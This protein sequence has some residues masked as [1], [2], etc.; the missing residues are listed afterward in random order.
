MP[1][2]TVAIMATDSV[3]DRGAIT[4]ALAM[5]EAEESH[6]DVYCIGVE[7]TPPDSYMA[8]TSV[9]VAPPDREAAR[10]RAHDLATE[11]AEL[12]PRH[13]ADVQFHPEMVPGGLLSGEVGRMARYADRIVATAPYGPEARPMH[14][15]V[16]EAALW[17][18]GMP[19]IVVPD[20]GAEIL[21]DPA[22]VA[23]AWDE[24]REAMVAVRTALPMLRRAG[25]VD[26]VT[27]G[28]AQ[29]QHTKPGELLALYLARN[30]VRAELSLLPKSL[31][32]V[33][34]V[35]R[36]HV[37]ETGAEQLVMGAY[38]HSRLREAVFGGTT[39]DMLGQPAVPLILAR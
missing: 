15:A 5:T 23:I 24:S 8:G 29:S 28:A 30:D 7:T 12:V 26:I 39:R 32:R 2:G 35:L 20:G 6:L 19:V 4:T 9:L 31:P 38:G 1:H 18:G 34:D 25:L 37:A 17:V 33:A 22:R 10:Q 16:L 36:Q 14:V 27:V 3:L 13:R 21:A 11:L